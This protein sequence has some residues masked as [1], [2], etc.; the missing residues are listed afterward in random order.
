MKK[1]K[2]I[3]ILLLALTLAALAGFVFFAKKVSSGLST[4]QSTSK[5]PVQIQEYMASNTLYPNANGVCTDWVELYNSSSADIDIGGFKLTDE[6]RKSRFTVPSGTIIPGNGYYVIYCLRSGGS[7]YADFGISRSGGEDLILLNRKNVLIDSVKTISLPENASA[8]RDESGEFSIS[9]QPSPGGPSL[10]DAPKAEPPAESKLRAVPG[11]II[12]NEVVQ[13]NTLYADERGLVTDIVELANTSDS[14]VDIG[15]YMLQNGIE[16]KQLEVPRGTVM[17]PGS[18]YLIHCARSQT[19]GLY[20]DF[21][22]SRNGGELLLLYTDSGVLTDFVTTEPCGKNESTVQENG[23]ARNSSFSTPGFA[24]TAEGW[25]ACL[26]MHTAAGSLRISEVMTSNKSITFHDETTPDWVELFNASVSDADISGY[27]L[28]DSAA[29]VR[30]VFPQGS[31]VPAGG[32]LVV[33]CDGN[34]GKAADAAHIGLSSKGG[35]TLFLTR[36]D[37][38]LCAAAMTAV[39]DPDVSLVYD[40]GVRP[41]VSKQPTPGFAND[42]SG[43]IAYQAT[44]PQLAVVPGLVISELMPN[45]S[46]T[47]VSADGYFADWVEL[48][49]EGSEQIELNRFCLSDK[50]SDLARFVLPAKTL[51]P[52]ERVLI[53]CSK[54]VRGNASEIWAPFG[55]SSKGGSVILSSVS[56]VIVDRAAYPVAESDRSFVRESSGAFSKT[57]C[58]TPGY[59]NTAAGYKEFL[60]AWVPSE[61]YISEVMPSNRTLARTGGEYYDWVELCNSSSSPVLLSGYCLTDDKDVPNKY[62]LPQVTLKSGGRILIYCSGDPSLSDETAYHC[63]FKL[64]SGE[65]TLYLFSADGR[66][67]DYLHIYK[68][69]PEGSIGRNGREGRILLYDAPTPL[70]ENKSGTELAPFSVMPVA[71]M[72]SGIYEDTESFFVTLSAKGTIYYTTDGSKPTAKSQV[73]TKPIQISKTSVLRAAALEEDKHL[74]DVLTLAYTINEGHG[75]PVLNLVMAPGDFS[76]AKGIYSH[77]NETWQKQG[78]IV[79]TDKNGTVTHDCGIRMS[80]QHSRTRAQKSFKLIF[81]DQYGGRLKYDV[82]GDTCE[83]KSFPQLLVRAGIDSKYAVYREPLIQKMAI[84]YRD[85]TFVQDSVPCVVYINGDYYGIYQFME[86]LC[87]ETLAD[88]LGVSTDS[89]TLFKGFMYPGHKN[90]EIYQLMEYVDSHDMTKKEYY[91]YAKSHLAF[92]DLIDWA[93]FEAYCHNADISGNV[94]YFKSTETDGRWHFVFYD[95]ECGFKV[96]ANFNAV[97]GDGQ[98]AVFLKALLR[99]GEFKDM[100]LR[101]I[102]FLCENAFRQEKVLDLLYSYDTLVRPE[103]ERHFKRWN[104]QPVTYIY[105]FNKI[106][107]LLKADRA[108][109]LKL[110]AKKYLKLSDAEYNKYFKG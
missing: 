86:S 76:G 56:G 37:G 61:L 108:T 82:F 54:S 97:L 74:S 93:I 88:R 91:E 57:D 89:I 69:P 70:K 104:L 4:N 14:S 60:S 5:F 24:N 42:E 87:E 81:S 21:A 33:L 27:G 39:S 66:L 13:G 73:Y 80:G 11:P 68:V 7:E 72:G 22:L 19:E 85:T 64:S 77:P 92:E 16:G 65:D 99:N 101:R 28:S 8:Q 26:A 51:S 15:G 67:M 110:S 50:E 78:C 106:E 23:V 32:Y 41:T 95:V 84:P 44:K 34:D 9:Y 10:P 49:N 107:K 18:F 75:L 6:N 79:Y 71:D 45:N 105:Q 35:E 3:A 2:M 12:I 17:A 36:T 53:W 38:T 102:E 52:G 20:A 40:G 63:P 100:F 29:S 47:N 94:R 30:Y 58:P 96:A 62:T 103:T 83:Q 31:V 109:E 90:L 1:K 46:C 48:Y 98:T 25:E 59:A 43:V 55:L